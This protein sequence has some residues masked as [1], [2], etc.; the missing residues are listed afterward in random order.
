MVCARYIYGRLSGICLKN[1]LGKAVSSIVTVQLY[2]QEFF[3]V[4]SSVR[5]SNHC[6][7][8][9]G[10]NFPGFK[11][12]ISSCCGFT[13]TRLCCWSILFLYPMTVMNIFACCGSFTQHVCDVYCNVYPN[14]LHVHVNFLVQH[15][16]VDN[17]AQPD[18]L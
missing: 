15:A 2:T 16:F 6:C 5:P 3:C 14:T 11:P 18:I 13:C 9:V 17:D 8:H 1:Y 12:Y 10:R 4:R 7:K